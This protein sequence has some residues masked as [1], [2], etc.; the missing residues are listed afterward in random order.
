[1]HSDPACVQG[2]ATSRLHKI[3]EQREMTLAAS[4]VTQ[5]GHSV[6]SGGTVNI[7]PVV[8]CGRGN[9]GKERQSNKRP[10]LQRNLEREAQKRL[11]ELQKLRHELACLTYEVDDVPFAAQDQDVRSKWAAISRQP[12]A[13]VGADTMECVRLDGCLKTK[14]HQM[15]AVEFPA[16]WRADVVNEEP[17]LD[18]SGF[19][20]EFSS[21]P[22]IM[23]SDPA[24]VQGVATSR[25]HTIHEQR[26]LTLAASDVTQDGHS[27]ASGGT[28]NISPVVGC[29]RRGNRR[30]ERQSNKRPDLQRNLE[31]EAQKRLLELQKLRHEL[32]LMQEQPG[33]SRVDRSK[34]TDLS[35]LRFSTAFTCIPAW[36]L[37]S[38]LE[39][40]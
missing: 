17:R 39:D 24:C 9:R 2:V 25:L 28:G 14:P 31:R 8:G 19:N 5:D 40:A 33:S 35:R 18:I 30:K 38:V 21:R 11:L 15:T 22:C 29:G 26:E 7:S 36:V 1:M 12:G 3:H 4:D 10:D 37:L 27:V 20:E 32:E 6:A 34:C 13:A 23:H 16:C